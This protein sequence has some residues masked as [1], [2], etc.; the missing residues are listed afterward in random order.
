MTSSTFSILAPG[1]L[2]ASRFLTALGSS[3]TG[4][5]LLDLQ[6]LALGVQGDVDRA[7]LDLELDLV[8]RVAVLDL[9]G[10][11]LDLG[12]GELLLDGLLT[13][14][15]S[16][17]TGI[18][19][20]SARAATASTESPRRAARPVTHRFRIVVLLRD[21]RRRD[22]PGDRAGPRAVAATLRRA[23]KPSLIRG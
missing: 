4:I 12:L 15:G 3:S 5:F 21:C 19:S 13:A 18:F 7:A 9:L 20:S 8:G 17:S 11:R 6:D 16:F 2:A 10:G 14:A 23:A 22:R 1:Y